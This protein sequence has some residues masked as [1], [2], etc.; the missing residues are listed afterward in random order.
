MYPGLAALFPDVVISEATVAQC[1][2]F[3]HQNNYARGACKQM[4]DFIY[5]GYLIDRYFDAVI[6]GGRWI[7]NE[8]PNLKETV[9]W[10]QHRGMRAVVFG[11]NIE[12]DLP[13]PRL[14]A[15]SL[16]EGTPSQVLRHRQIDPELLD[17]KLAA[18]VRNNWGA[19]YISIYEDLCTHNSV[20][21][22]TDINR[23]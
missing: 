7:D 11:P 14:L 21:T 12:Y 15:F 18:M 1:R 4:S 17:G 13:L 22:S 2:P 10:I 5:R 6:L 9:E 20:G 3:L 23:S 16:R 19:T 8:I